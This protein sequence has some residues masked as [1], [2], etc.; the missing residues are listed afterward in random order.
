MAN[1][2][3]SQLAVRKVFSLAP[4]IHPGS[5]VILLKEHTAYTVNRVLAGKIYLQRLDEQEICY[6]FEDATK[7][8]ITAITSSHIEA[9]KLQMTSEQLSHKLLCDPIGVS[10][11]WIHGTG[12]NSEHYGLMKK[13][14]V[15]SIL[16]EEEWNTWKTRLIRE[17][18]VPQ[19]P[20]IKPA[21]PQNHNFSRLEASSRPKQHIIRPQNFI[22]RVHTFNCTKQGHQLVSVQAEILVRTSDGKGI[23]SRLIPAGYCMQCTRYYVLSTFMDQNND[24]LKYAL[25]DIVGEKD[26]NRYIKSRKLETHGFASQSILNKCGYS[27]GQ[28]SQLTEDERVGLLQTIIEKRIL[29]MEEVRS[30]INWLIRFHGTDPSMKGAVDEWECDLFALKKNSHVPIVRVGAIT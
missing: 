3:N 11:N 22:V 9:V 8:K 16:S 28:S 24:I 2:R 4:S 20:I 13:F 21:K 5:Y 30:F 26:L 7:L 27:V 10:I 23:T 19:L 17:L 18:G 14:L 29:S 1:R 6:T 15:P 12:Y 25:C